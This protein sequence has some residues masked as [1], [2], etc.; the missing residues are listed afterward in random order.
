VIPQI[1]VS[2]AGPLIAF[3]QVNRL[4]LLSH[5][6]VHVVVRPVVARE[7]APSLGAL[8][9]WIRIQDV[10]S[11]P[12]FSRNLGLGKS[13]AIALAMK[14][15]ADFLVLDD[16]GARAVATELGISVIGSLELLVR[17]K[18]SGQIDEVRP[19]M[20]AMISHRFYASEG[21]RRQILT[22]AGE[23]PV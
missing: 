8:P 14:L 12:S 17:A 20:D 2:D 23:T 1:G 5:L 22:V 19:L 15:A 11:S 6:F 3:H 10:Q 16:G 7:V 21:L 13:K 18:Q 4:E 9:S